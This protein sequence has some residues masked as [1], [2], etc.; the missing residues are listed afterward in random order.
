MDDETLAAY[1]DGS[2]AA[3]RRAAVDEHVDRCG[4]CRRLLAAVGAS[5]DGQG[6]AVTDQPHQDEPGPSPPI[7][8]GR[9]VR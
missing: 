1:V 2:L 8:G 3:A 5:E 6:A 7:A 9:N 4:S